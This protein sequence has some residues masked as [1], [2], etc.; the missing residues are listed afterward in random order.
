MCVFL[1]L[2]CNVRGEGEGYGHLQWQKVWLAQQHDRQHVGFLHILLF[3]CNKQTIPSQI[4][5]S[6]DFADE[7]YSSTN[8]FQIGRAHV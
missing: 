5:T 7:K 6:V 4:S 2:C 1:C 3:H 8:L